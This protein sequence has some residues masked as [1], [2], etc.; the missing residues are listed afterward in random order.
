MQAMP[1]IGRTAAAVLGL[2][3]GSAAAAQPQIDGVRDGFYGPPM[4]V[5]TSATAFGVNDVGQVD[6]ANGSALF[7]GLAFVSGRTLYLHLAGNL[8]TNFNKLELFIDS[9]PGGQNRLR[10][11][12][13][14]VDFNGLNRMA[15]P[16]ACSAC[17]G[18][19]RGSPSSRRA[20]AGRARA[21]RPGRRSA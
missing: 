21:G 20:A 4:V 5:Q 16:A 13:A 11:D 18:R 8:E 10:G 15:A 14:D 12:N 2:S 7:S 17:R 3:L 9:G 6:E 1:R 19:H